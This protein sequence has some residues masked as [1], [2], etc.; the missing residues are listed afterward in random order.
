MITILDL[1]DSPW[2]DGPGR[3]VLETASR[4]NKQ[5]YKI[6]IGTFNGGKNGNQYIESAKER[7]L[8]IA[9]VDDNGSFDIGAV[10]K[11]KKLI[12]KYNV[13]I[14]HTHEFRSNLFGVLAARQKRIPIV[15]TVHGWIV[16]SKKD[17]LYSFADKILLSFFDSVVTVSNKHSDFLNKRY[18]VPKRKLLTVHNTLEVGSYKVL[19]GDKEFK[20]SLGLK[21]SDILIANIGRLSPEKGQDI[22]L[23]AAKN[24]LAKHDNVYFTLIGIGPDQ[25]RLE[26]MVDCLGIAENVI[27]SGYQKNMNSVYNGLDL[28]VQSSYTEG[29][30]NVVLEALLLEVPVIATDVGGTAEIMTN[31][32]EGLLIPPKSLEI[33]ERSILQFLENPEELIQMARKGRERILQDFNSDGRVEK[34]EKLYSQLAQKSA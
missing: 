34:L 16:N 3:T 14:L 28:V 32:C 19:R 33:L 26:E 5:K 18:F 1:R 2:V 23:R 6:I 9:V 12:R 11:I 4:I 22:F 8:E 7:G 13:D 20:S 31:M 25:S 29:M 24:I 27:F 17:L 21:G 10:A 30:P 15:T